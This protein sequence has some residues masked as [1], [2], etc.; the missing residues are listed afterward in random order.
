[1]AFLKKQKLILLR[2]WRKIKQTLKADA[3]ATD[4]CSALYLAASLLPPSSPDKVIIVL[5]DMRQATSE[6]DLESPEVIDVNAALQKAKDQDLIPEL[7]GVKAVCLGVS[8]AKSVKYAKSLK[9]FW[10]RF[11]RYGGITG[12]I[13]YT[14]ERSFQNE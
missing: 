12:D 14:M 8:S 2:E 11:L 5:S 3:V 9:N 7:G 13:I 6:L 1:M 10:L 4:I